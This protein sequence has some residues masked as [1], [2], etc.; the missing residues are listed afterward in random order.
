MKHF[1]ISL[2]L[3]FLVILGSSACKHDVLFTDMDPMVNPMDTTTTTPMDTTTTNPMDTTT[4]DPGTNVMM[5]D[6]DTIYFATD[7][8]PILAGNCAYSGCHDVTTAADGIILNNYT[9]VIGT[10]SVTPF[11]LNDSD[12]YENITETDPDKIMPPP[13]NTALSSEQINIIAKWIQQGAQNLTCDGG[14]GASTCETT[15]ISYGGFIVPLLQTYCL[16][17]HSAASASGGIV[18]EGYANVNTYA[19]NGR[20]YGS[21]ARLNGFSPMP[22]GQGQLPDC[23]IAKLKSWIDDGAQNN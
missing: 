14:T 4:T 20:L 12:L 23:D 7:V 16:G 1:R 13:P 11:D 18:L 22:Q 2:Q 9:N 17:C 8:L 6:P 15:S 10:R 3:I 21:V 5:C 19:M